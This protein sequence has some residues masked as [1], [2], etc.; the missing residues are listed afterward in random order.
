MPSDKKR[1]I[2]NILNELNHK[3]SAKSK[4]QDIDDEVNAILASIGIE[5][6]PKK[7]NSNEP[8]VLT[9][10][11]NYNTINETIEHDVQ[12]VPERKKPTVINET[13]KPKIISSAPLIEPIIEGEPTT[14]ELPNVKEFSEQEQRRAAQMARKAGEEKLQRIRE[15][16]QKQ[17]LKYAKQQADL[18]AKRQAELKAMQQNDESAKIAIKQNTTGELKIA[19]LK[20]MQKEDEIAKSTNK[21]ASSK[22]G[23][24]PAN[25]VVPNM[26]RLQN[27]PRFLN[28]FSSSVANDGTN[29]GISVKK[30]SASSD[31]KNTPIKGFS[32]DDVKKSSFNSKDLSM[33]DTIGALPALSQATASFGAPISVE[34]ES[35][36]D[37]AAIAV[38]SENYAAHDE[39]EEDFVSDIIEVDVSSKS[40]V[41]NKFVV[42]EEAQSDIEDSAVVNVNAFVKDDV[43]P[44]PAKS[45]N[46]KFASKAKSDTDDSFWSEKR[47]NGNTSK[48]IGIDAPLVQTAT[49]GIDPDK[50]GVAPINYDENEDYNQL[51]DAP[52]I[53]AKLSKKL[54]ANIARTILTAFLSIGLIAFSFIN[55]GVVNAS[56]MANADANTYAFLLLNLLGLIIGA[57]ACFNIMAS[58]AIGLFKH[59][60][61]DTITLF[62]VL[63]ALVQNIICLVLPSQY[64]AHNVT[65]FSGVAVL[66]LFF[67]SLGKILQIKSVIGNFDIV[68]KSYEHYAAF[69]VK[70]KQL[71]NLVCKGLREDKPSLLVS[72][73]T[74]LMRGFMRHSFSSTIS[75]VYGRKFSIIIMLVS[76]ACALIAGL[77]TPEP[78]FI[79]SAFAGAVCIG[80]PLATSLVYSVVAFQLQ[81]SAK[82][83]GAAIPGS[84]AVQSLGLCNTVLLRVRDLFPS[85]NV[86]LSSIK[87]FEGKRI[88]LA[89]LYAASIV[90]E[91]CE[92]LAD[93]FLA[94][95][96]ND[97]NALFEVKHA[98]TEFN[99]GVTGYVDDK[100]VI[101]GNREMMRRYQIELP[102]LEYERKFTDNGEKCAIYLSVNGELFSL[103]IVSYEPN[104]AAASML[105]ILSNSGIN[106]LI[107]S[108]DFNVSEA[109]ITS[110]YHVSPEMIKILSQ[111]EKDMIT[112]QT[113]YL[114]ESEGYMIHKNTIRSFIGGLRAA[115]KAAQREKLANTV[116]LAGVLIAVLL[117]IILGFTGNLVSISLYLVLLFQIV[118]CAITILPIIF[119]K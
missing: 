3:P 80:S 17:Q 52:E 110:L 94:V 6:S 37:E 57:A 60:S 56:V 99:L 97:I 101:F 100:K 83:Y 34:E 62:A 54:N 25:A 15:Q 23:S 89:V 29:G 87:P 49:I 5:S 14:Y 64:E 108:N 45:F 74:S 26:Q 28:F 76:V 98:E 82:K 113:E 102:S 47:Y 48:E 84:S 85:S 4:A 90:Y 32:L 86:V 103:F 7:K 107:Y 117:A 72:R 116:E 104:K 105:N 30:K 81:K 27:D 61:V 106:S 8:L 36:I 40:I 88:D 16:E 111:S 114:P 59:L 35:E 9:P 38:I 33:Q 41:Q 71:T 95:V 79:I 69:A 65:L 18:Q 91:N 50:Y 78:V 67:N 21:Q 39:V 1:D 55:D 42:D 43:A 73:P 93:T 68:S 19:E 53:E 51:A 119:K 2:D 115:S 46:N 118:W 31:L 11:I 75:D 112:S 70:N 66:L 58:G 109:L 13:A 12:K 92:T 63:G 20:A 10:D 77:N 44:V 96:D 24:R 22:P